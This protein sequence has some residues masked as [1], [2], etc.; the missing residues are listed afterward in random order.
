M[1]IVTT[2]ELMGRKAV[3]G[4]K[5]KK[6]GKVRRFIFHPSEK[7]V[8]GLTV[9]RPDAALMFHRKDLFVS[10][11]GFEIDE[12]G[13]LVVSD[14][15]EATDKGACKALGVD[16]EQCVLWVGMPVMTAKGDFLGYVD[17]VAFDCE[18]GAISHIKTENGAANDVLLGKFKVPGNYIKG[19]RRGQGMALSQMGE[20]GE[21]EDDAEVE[22]GAI[23]VADRTVELASEG[24]VAEK[25]GKATAVV[26]DKAKK[27]AD[28]AKAAAAE[29]VEKAR[30]V[31]KRAAEITGDAVNKGAFAA[32]K[33]IGKTKGMF[34][35]FKEEFEKASKGEG[36]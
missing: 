1:A 35:A 13:S 29:K 36:E 24:G 21:G 22:R 27:S 32:G 33:Q 6:I 4:K 16:W 25:A 34:S 28:K 8:V 26:T 30:P 17:E 5:L 14:A 31:A 3:G 23:L 20:F 12:E 7:R 10:L 15:P 9:K 18:T 2:K 19:F 11:G